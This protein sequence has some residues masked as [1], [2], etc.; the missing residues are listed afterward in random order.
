MYEGLNSA[1]ILRQ[2]LGQM[3]DTDQR[4]DRNAEINLPT[5]WTSDDDNTQAFA[6]ILAAKGYS[7]EPAKPRAVDPSQCAGLGQPLRYS[8]EDQ[9]LDRL[10]E[11]TGADP[12]HSRSRR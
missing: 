8:A 9:L 1:A 10:I 7:E 5:S 6:K 2:A 12:R 11:I 4:N 3:I